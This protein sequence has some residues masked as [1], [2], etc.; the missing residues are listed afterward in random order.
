MSGP[1]LRAKRA[2]GRLDGYTVAG[3]AGITRTRLSDLER[4]RFKP[5]P[6]ELQK[7]SDA[8]DQIAA[9]RKRISELAE[10]HG[11]SLQAAGL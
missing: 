1:Q 4:E 5:R 3:R 7:I 11:L 9:E 10:S 6:G 2:E 8:I